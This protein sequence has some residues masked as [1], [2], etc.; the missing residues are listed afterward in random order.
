MPSRQEVAKELG[1]RVSRGEYERLLN[2]RFSHKSRVQSTS[3]GKRT[4]VT[5]VTT[6]LHPAAPKAKRKHSGENMVAEEVKSR[7]A[8]YVFK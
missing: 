3:R 7:R 5:R 1:R 6:V 2:L 8:R 4:G